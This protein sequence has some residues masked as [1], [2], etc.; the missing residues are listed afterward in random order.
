MEVST[1]SS[2]PS[3]FAD[4]I[5]GILKLTPFRYAN[6]P[7]PMSFS[8]ITL[9]SN[10]IDIS[11]SETEED[12]TKAIIAALTSIDITIY[13]WVFENDSPSNISKMGQ[14]SFSDQD[15][16]DWTLDLSRLFFQQVT[17][18]AQQKRLSILCSDSLGSSIVM[19]YT[20][21]PDIQSIAL[22]IESSPIKSFIKSISLTEPT[23]YFL[24]LDN[25]VI[26]LQGIRRAS[27]I[28][29]QMPFPKPVSKCVSVSLQPKIHM[30]NGHSSHDVSVTD[31]FVVFGQTTGGSLYANQRLLV[32]DCSSFL[33]TPAHLIFT[34]AQHLLKF[35]HLTDVERKL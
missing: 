11:V 34:T 19:T 14:L 13:E 1:T 9:S 12:S 31:E 10:I 21:V 24:T 22:H 23:P 29:K 8:E 30:T 35:V 33:V 28:Q 6:V 15:C 7:P 32:R 20:L 4:Q 25:Q 5:A 18:S 3:R 16:H 26:A 17:C 27:H 2:S